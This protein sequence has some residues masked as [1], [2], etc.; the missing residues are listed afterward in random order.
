MNSTDQPYGQ[1]D[2]AHMFTEHCREVYTDLL[3]DLEE[4]ATL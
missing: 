3:V 4:I 2:Y 1:Y